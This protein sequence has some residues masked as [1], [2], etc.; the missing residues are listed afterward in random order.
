MVI[1]V[2]YLTYSD[3]VTL[4]GTLTSNAFD[5]LEYEVE[6]QID[7]KTFGRLVDKEVP[8]EVKLCAFR[9]CSLVNKYIENKAKGNI[10]SES[11]GS[12]SVSY[13]SVSDAIKSQEA[14]ITN[15]IKTYLI[16]TKID[17][18]PVLYRGTR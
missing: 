1:E 10:S 8:E 2:R 3:Y 18:V 6:K 15:T 7:L 16:N 11:V 14:E 13:G 12:Y 4:G 9:L 17:N 5:L